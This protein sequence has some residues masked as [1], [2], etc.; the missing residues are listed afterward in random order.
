MSSATDK[1]KGKANE[2]AGKVKQGIGKAV[3]NDRMRA[4]GAFQES[5]GDAQQAI[6]KG[7][8][9]VKKAVDRV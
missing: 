2:M 4:E 8:D 7:K 1:I 3:G 6:G 9:A 5:K